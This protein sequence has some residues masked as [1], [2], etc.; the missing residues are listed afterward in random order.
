MEYTSPWRQFV[1]NFTSRKSA[2]ISLAVLFLIFVAAF[3]GPYFTLQDPYDLAQI[4]ILDSSLPPGSTDM[5]GNTFWLGTDDQ[6]RDLLSAIIY[7]LRISLVVGV[8]SGLMA[9]VVG[10]GIGIIGAYF[11]GRIDS[12]I[13]RVVDLFLGFPS[14]LI[15]LICLAVLGRGV[16]KV[17]LALVLSQWATFARIVRGVAVVEREK[18]YID[19]ARGLVLPRHRIIFGH[20]LPNCLPP[21]IVVATMNVAFSITLEASL[22]FL[23]V[24]LPITEP[25]LG[26]LIANGY[27]YI[28]TG[29]Y[30]LSFYPGIALLITVMSLNLVADHLRRV[31]NPRLET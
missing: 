5:A 15:A 1:E 31:L 28:L 23:G 19:S 25:S 29:K 11:G 13:M 17:V 9:V 30:W 6:G 7:G 2:V 12:L 21:L 20:L 14:F 26:L 3:V 16:E 24:G 27:E 10:V 22:S 18:E 8:V 4:S